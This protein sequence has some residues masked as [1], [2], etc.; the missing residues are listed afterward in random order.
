MSNNGKSNHVAFEEKIAAKYR[1]QGFDV[2]IEPQK[3]ELPFD[4]NSY[5]PDLIA[6]KSPNE[7]YIIE[8]KPSASRLSVD[9]YREIAELVSEHDGWRFLLVTGE[10]VPTNGQ[11]VEGK[12]LLSQKQMLQ[13]FGNAERL[14]LL[15]E[16]EGAF[17][18]LWGVFE[19]ALR[20]QA[21]KALIPIDLFN[22]QKSLQTEQISGGS[23]KSRCE[24]TL[25]PRL[26]GRSDRIKGQR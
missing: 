11:G 7:G 20:W 15:G 8:I 24:G 2:V 12:A 23:G 4:L 26:D 18:S 5:H 19:A 6:R 17:L 16:V 9:R 10:D 14:L 25:R 13:R 22:N 21:R 1:S 3:N